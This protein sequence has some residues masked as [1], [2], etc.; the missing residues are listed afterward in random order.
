MADAT[1]VEDN[2]L[3]LDA[4][5]SQ[6]Q[7]ARRQVAAFLAGGEE[8]AGGLADHTASLEVRLQAVCQAVTAL[9]QSFETHHQA[10]ITELQA[11]ILAGTQVAE[12]AVG[13][14]GTR[15]LDIEGGLERAVGHT[16]EELHR[17]GGE[18][19]Q[20]SG[21]AANAA[22]ELEETHAE[23]GHHVNDAGLALRAG[24]LEAG[25][26]THTRGTETLNALAG[27]QDYV[28]E[29]LE[30][31]LASA[32][33]IFIGELTEKTQPLL[34]DTLGEV[35]R[36]VLR[37]LDELDALV[38]TV[39]GRLADETEPALR[40]TAGRLDDWKDD[41]R[42]RLE[43]SG[44]E[45]QR[46]YTL[47]VDRHVSMARKGQEVASDVAQMVPQLAAARQVAERVQDLLDVMN[48]FG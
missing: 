18:L 4:F 41:L 45:A 44:Q 17:V 33:G 16:R 26:H 38:E 35:G 8:S 27:A 12:Q 37:C 21:H 46:P 3:R 48:P 7:A 23:H 32:F 22:E 2:L 31:Y 1:N 43:G 34:V 30:K 11:L 10:V 36:T 42:R 9:T 19:A 24:V 5:L 40:D 29:G 39:A 14:T 25:E 47:E 13:G 28:A 15:L 6:A 20:A